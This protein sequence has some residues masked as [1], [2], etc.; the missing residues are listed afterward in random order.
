VAG[1]GDSRPPIFTGDTGG[2]P[3]SVTNGGGSSG[4]AGSGSGPISLAEDASAPP[5]CDAG[6][7]GNVCGCLDLSLLADPPNMYFLLDRSGSMNE[8]NKWVTIRTV[9]VDVMHRIGPRA[10]FGAAVFPDP[11]ATDACAVGTEAMP[12]TLG[13][14]PAGTYGSTAALFTEATNVPASGGTPTAATV[15]K[16]ASTLAGLPGKTFVV[17]ATDGGPNCDAA[18]MCDQSA[19]IPNIESDTGCS[20]D[21][22]PNCCAQDPYNCLD[23]FAAV[24]A[25]GDLAAAGIPTYVVGVPGSGPYAGLLNQMAMAGGTARPTT[26]NYYPVDTADTNAFTATLSAVAAQITATCTLTLSQPPPD[27][28]KVNVYLDGV[29]VPADP[30]N[31]WIL[32][33]STIT[34]EGT[35]CANVLSGMS[36]DLRI[37]A[38]CPTILR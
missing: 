26:P 8:S 19:C 10:R 28:T 33:G 37:V 4:G 34:L 20:P 35:T 7:Q 22:G 31:G 3:T 2:G 25:I 17:L 27:P 38:G 9:I 13:D 23:S 16:L 36:L 12:L 24:K 15:S 29:A 5:G 21:G 14:A 18:V 11:R 1:C 6:L 30:T 32:S